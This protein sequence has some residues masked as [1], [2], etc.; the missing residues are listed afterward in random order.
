M[1]L[2]ADRLAKLAGLPVAKRS[3]LTEA[4]NRSMHEDPSVSDE[5]DHRFGKG[6]LAEGDEETAASAEVVSKCVEAGKEWQLVNDP[7]KKFTPEDLEKL[8]A[9]CTQDGG[10]GLQWWDAEKG[11][12]LLNTPRNEGSGAKKGDQSK[13]RLDYEGTDADDVVEIDD[14]MLSEE[15]ARIRRERLEENELRSIIRNEI[16]SIMS[17]IKKA[18]GTSTKRRSRK[19]KDSFSGITAGFPG[20]GFR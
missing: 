14:A 15:I 8:E 9:S 7:N 12:G 1:D 6:Q 17:S 11:E 13:S 2:Y 5:A 20:P 3:S 19:M 4:S 16:G 10:E 18:G